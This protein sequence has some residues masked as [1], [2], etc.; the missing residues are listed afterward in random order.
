M[1][2]SGLVYL[3][4]CTDDTDGDMLAVVNASHPTGLDH[5]WLISDEPFASGAPSPSPCE[6]IPGRRHIL[7]VC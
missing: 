2:S 3:S 5:G 4:V 7:L 6:M 1:Y